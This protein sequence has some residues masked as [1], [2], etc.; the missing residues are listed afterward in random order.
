MLSHTSRAVWSRQFNS[1]L[2]HTFPSLLFTQLLLVW[3]L[4]HYQCIPVQLQSCSLHSEQDLFRLVRQAHAYAWAVSPVGFL[5]GW[6]GRKQCVADLWDHH[7]C[8]LCVHV[9]YCVDVLYWFPL[10]ALVLLQCWQQFVGSMCGE[11]VMLL[12]QTGVGRQRDCIVAVQARPCCALYRWS[13]RTQMQ[14]GF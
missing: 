5:G 1:R 13:S 12:Q 3:Q 4:Y 11:P 10:L 8:T 7:L 14:S 2:S 9:C 6:F